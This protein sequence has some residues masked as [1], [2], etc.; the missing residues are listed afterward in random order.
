MQIITLYVAICSLM[1]ISSIANATVTSPLDRPSSNCRFGDQ[2]VDHVI[3]YG[4]TTFSDTAVDGGTFVSGSLALKNAT[5]D[6]MEIAG[7]AKMDGAF[8]NG[9]TDVLGPLNAKFCNFEGNVLI[10]SDKSTLKECAVNG[11]LTMESKDKSPILELQC[12]TKISGN[13]TFKGKPGIVKK[14]KD[15]TLKGHVVNGKIEIVKFK[16]KCS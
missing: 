12:G 13:L 9:N 14:S 6:N 3:C 8:V 2:E 5:L 15:S 16:V 4:S 1:L 7:N 10:N 11:S